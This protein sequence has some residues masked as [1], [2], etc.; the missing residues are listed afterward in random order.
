VGEIDILE[1]WGGNKSLQ[2]TDQYAHATVHWNNQSNTMNPVHNKA[3]GKP[4]ETPDGSKLHNN[5]LVYWAEWTPTNISIGVNEFTYFIVNTTNMP[6]SINPVWA[7][8]GKWPYRLLLDI[9]I[10][11]YF[12]GPP[13]NT[14]V[15]PQQMV[16]DWVRVYQT[17]K[18]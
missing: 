2:D 16:V 15:W 10:N 13:D 12:P 6:D 9:A 14:T 7:F 8:S 1:M 4:W 11:G 17:K 5:S 18:P 3:I